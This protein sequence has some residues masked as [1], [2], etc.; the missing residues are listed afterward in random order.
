MAGVFFCGW[1]AWG[2]RFI[3]RNAG[4]IRSSVNFGLGRKSGRGFIRTIEA[5][6]RRYVGDI[7][8]TG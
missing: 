6:I 3:R 7:R 1:G 2:G 4:D 8:K 5:V